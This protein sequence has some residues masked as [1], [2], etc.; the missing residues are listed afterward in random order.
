M[1]QKRIG[2]FLRELRKEKDL[3]QGQLAEQLN[4]SDRTVSRWENGN[5]MPDLSVLVELADFY[6]VDIKEIIDGERKSEK[7][8]KE[9]KDTLLKVAEYSQFEKKTIKKKIL[10]YTIVA[11]ALMIMALILESTQGFGCMSDQ[12]IANITDFITGIAVGSMILNI[13]YLTGT[14]EKIHVYKMKLIRRSM[15]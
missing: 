8:E 15:N 5:N 3:T 13:L 11:L 6:D 14:M 10:I 12:L 7:M 9:T 2:S 4:V 1:D